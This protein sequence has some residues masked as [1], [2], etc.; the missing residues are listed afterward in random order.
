MRLLLRSLL[1]IGLL[2][3]AD[4]LAFAAESGSSEELETAAPAQSAGVETN[5]EGPH[6]EN[7][8]H[9]PDPPEVNW[10]DLG[11]SKK[12]VHGAPLVH[13]KEP[14][15][16]PMFWALINFAVFAGLMYWKAGPALSK[17]LANRHESIKGALEE[18]AR[19]QEQA[20]EKMAEY[21]ARIADA[22][23]EVNALIAQIR[24]DAELERENIVADAKRQAER[25]KTEAE[26][27]IENEFIRARRQLEAEV[28]G[29]AAEVAER[30]LGEKASAADH[31]ALFANFITDI[32]SA[33]DAS[34]GEQV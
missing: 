3:G 11:Y 6:H 29:K 9:V 12:D 1:T 10:T 18:A 7:A 5:P 31:S 33:K 22:D 25:M 23:A 30:L 20:K 15:A 27:S 16:P 19:L 24:K 21:S 8:H 28:I 2:S 4:Q 14:M 26:A 32:K 13:G 17:Y 34:N